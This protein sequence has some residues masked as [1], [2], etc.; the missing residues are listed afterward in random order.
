MLDPAIQQFL[1]ERKAARLKTKLNA[2]MSD[3]QKRET[4]SLANEEFDLENW[5]PNAAKRACWLSISS[6]PC[7]FSH[8]SSR[9]HP[10]SKTKA[11]TTG[12]IANAVFKNDGFLRTGNINTETELDVFGNAAALDVY[13][14]LSLKLSDTQ[15]VLDHLEANTAFIQQQFTLASTPFDEIRLGLLAI[16][17]QVSAHQITSERVKQVYFPVAEDYHLL[18]ILTPSGLMFKLRE[19]IN[20][21]RFS[22]ASK[23]AREA[24]K[25]NAFHEQGFDE[26]Y[27]LTAIGFGGTKPQNIS[28]LNSQYGG[29]AYLLKSMPPDIIKRDLNPP[30]NNF[31]KNSLYLKNYQDSFKELH[32]L[33][34]LEYNN[35]DIRLGIENC[36]NFILSNVIEQAWRVRQL[37]AGW[38]EKTELKDY[39]KIWLDNAYQTQREE[40]EDWLEDVI[41][42]IAHWFLNSYKKIIGEHKAESLGDAELIHLKSLVEPLIENQKG[43]LL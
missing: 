37:E 19:H 39:Q 6:H 43:G 35:K 12:I 26:L 34:I 24:K 27:D 38:S 18:S 17:S 29:V 8:P 2:N 16:K 36:I 20:Q 30:K 15:S 25:N 7:T 14:F 1:D 41:S 28:N 23:Q 5:L 13:K 40:Q 42:E 31:F 22:E 9:D 32:K 3:E 11:K 33:M 21:I 4:E 10:S